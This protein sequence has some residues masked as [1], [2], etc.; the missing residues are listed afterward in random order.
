MF[1]LRYLPLSLAIREMLR[2][3]ALTTLKYFECPILDVGCGDGLF[4]EALLY[5]QSE[6]KLSCL[7]NLFGIDISESELEL[8]CARFDKHGANSLNFDISS[9]R[10]EGS[11]LDHLRGKCRSVIAN[12]SLE[13]VP[14]IQNALI[15]I[16]DCLAPGRTF[17][18]FLPHPRWTR[19]LAFHNLISRF[20]DRL[21]G[22]YAGLFDGFFQHYHLYPHYVWKAL[23][24]SC[25]FGDVDIK[26]IGSQS[27][28]RY[29]S[30]WIPASMPA[31]AWKSVSGKYPSWY[32][33]VKR[34]YLKRQTGLLKELVDLSFIKDDL[35]DPSIVE[36]FI[37]CTNVE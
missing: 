24:E 27:T 37:R 34:A 7:K 20:S 18:L 25:G 29:F 14:D 9:H 36:F 5:D 6:T 21:G 1:L 26:G 2:I 19:S 30:N 8:C 31:F 11:E 23:L 3:R 22:C 33:F 4:W 10:L 35:E 15:N 16:K 17:V 32:S 28:N 13:H 12:C